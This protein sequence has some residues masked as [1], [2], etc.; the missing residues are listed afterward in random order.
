MRANVTAAAPLTS[1]R[2]TVVEFAGAEFGYD[3]TSVVHDIDLRVSA[4]EL[5]GLLGPSGAGKTTLLRA[6]LGQV[7]PRRGVVR[8]DGVEARRGRSRVGYVPQL[9]TVDW[10]F[11][12]TVA[13][14]VG[15]GLAADAGIWP[16]PRAEDRRR[17]DEI[18]ERLGIAHLARRHI[19]ALSG[20]QQQRVFLARA[21][22]RRPTLLVL[23]EPTSGA[24]A[25]TRHEVIE[26]LHDQHRDGMAVILT[27]HD[28]NGVAAK[29]P[30]LVALNQTVVADGAPAD[31]F[32]PAVLRATFGAEMIVLEH[33]G[34]L[35]TADLPDDHR[36]HGTHPHHA[37]VHHGEPHVET[38]ALFAVEAGSCTG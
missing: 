27:T 7:R 38:L 6:L 31:V 29:L 33:D 11:P 2:P 10:S 30:R 22:L 3:A 8:V 28:L 16:W 21:L 36:T 32:T 15:M 35:I 5:V 23:D 37:H 12:V 13:D 34:L 1:S 20:G 4:G 26:L 24:D 17:R 18:L 9:D 14:V 25:A 19:R